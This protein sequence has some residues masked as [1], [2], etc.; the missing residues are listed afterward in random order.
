MMKMRAEIQERSPQILKINRSNI[1]VHSIK[2][3]NE[4]RNPIFDVSRGWNSASSDTRPQYS[5]TKQIY[6]LNS[7]QRSSILYVHLKTLSQNYT[8]VSFC[9]N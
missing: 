2:V 8:D 5:L 6:R 4:A 1:V 3:L 7:R 9:K